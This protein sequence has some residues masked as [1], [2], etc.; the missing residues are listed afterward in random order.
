MGSFKNEWQPPNT[1][2]SMSAQMAT[3]ILIV[4]DLAKRSGLPAR[5]MSEV[6]EGRA[7]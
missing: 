2:I 3:V 6:R 5:K 4:N 7:A 1:V